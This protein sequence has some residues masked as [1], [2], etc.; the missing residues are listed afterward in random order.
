MLLNTRVQNSHFW[1]PTAKNVTVHGLPRL[2]VLS[3]SMRKHACTMAACN[4][5]QPLGHSRQGPAKH[6][7]FIL[8]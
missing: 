2:T 8:L 5:P 6:D 3:H 1:T 4:N 7:T